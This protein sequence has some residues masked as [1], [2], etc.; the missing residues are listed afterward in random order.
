MHQSY[1]R[2][3]WDSPVDLFIGNYFYLLVTKNKKFIIST[4]V[5]SIKI[6]LLNVPAVNEFRV[7]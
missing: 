4:F 1:H 2:E 7:K 3:Q 5:I 6:I